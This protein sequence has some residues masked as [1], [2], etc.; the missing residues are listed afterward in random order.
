MSQTETEL[1]NLAA[2]VLGGRGRLVTTQQRS[3]VTDV[4]NLWYP[5]VRKQVLA[6][7]HWPSCSKITRLA[8]VKERTGLE[9]WDETEPAPGAKYAYARP[10]DMLRPRELTSGL[11]FSL[12]QIGNNPCI[13]THLPD[14]ILHYTFDQISTGAWENELFLAVAHGLAAFSAMTI[15]GKSSYVQFAENKANSLIAQART[16]AANED[17]GTVQA[18]A[19]WHAARGYLASPTTTRFLFPHGDMLNVGKSADVQ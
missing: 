10:A 9:A 7:A 11:A 19:S 14:Q 4:F 8:L 5:F 16:T 18:V 2:Q 3:R 17:D 12:G 1:F 6:A 13:F 15:T